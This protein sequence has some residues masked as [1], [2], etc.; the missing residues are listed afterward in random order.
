MMTLIFANDA[1]KVTLCMSAHI[2]EPDKI[3]VVRTRMS[4]QMLLRVLSAERKAPIFL[5]E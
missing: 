3:T 5:D 1:A 4:K 2:L